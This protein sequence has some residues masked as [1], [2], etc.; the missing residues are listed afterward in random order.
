VRLRETLAFPEVSE[1]EVVRHF[2][3]LSILN[4]HIDRGLYPLGSCTM[5]HNPKINDEMAALPG[6]A[7]SHPLAGDE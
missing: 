2:T 5:K 4:H 3:E 7:R 1:P 6:F